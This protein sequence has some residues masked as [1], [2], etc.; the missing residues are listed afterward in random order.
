MLLEMGWARLHK[1]RLSLISLNDFRFLFSCSLDFIIHEGAA[2]KY[3]YMVQTQVV[4]RTRANC[5]FHYSARLRSVESGDTEQFSRVN[6]TD[7]V[8]V[9]QL[10]CETTR[11]TLFV[12]C[13]LL[14][15]LC[16]TNVVSVYVFI[17]SV[18]TLLTL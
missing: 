16:L 13:Q 9:H 6:Y 17:L 1:M 12:H 18:T 4:Q 10:V 3:I 11:N 8:A 14:K 7:R 15:E 5:Q 2:R